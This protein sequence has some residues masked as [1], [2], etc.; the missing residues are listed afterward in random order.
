M[1]YAN[2]D[3]KRSKPPP[4]AKGTCTGCGA[5]VLAKCG[6]IKVH[7]WAHVAKDC[8]PWYEPMTEWHRTWQER[9]PPDW[10]E[11]T[12]GPHRADVCTPGGLVL[13][14]QHSPIGFEEIEEREN[15]YGNMLWVFDA[16]MRRMKEAIMCNT[17][18]WHSLHISS[19]PGDILLQLKH[20]RPS[21]LA[22]GERLVLDFGPY[23]LFD[24]EEIM[25]DGFLGQRLGCDAFVSSIS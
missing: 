1:Q 10:R 22:V 21:L 2:V 17:S 8:D 7:H 5:P 9:F 19:K 6:T 20:A 25:T 24:V 16:R 13:E 23:G 15:F 18:P 11:V 14:F 12:I 3:G 4:G